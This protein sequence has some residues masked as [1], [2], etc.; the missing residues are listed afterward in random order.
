MSD[1]AR[2]DQKMPLGHRGE[3]SRA[4]LLPAIVLIIV[5]DFVAR[6]HDTEHRPG[7]LRPYGPSVA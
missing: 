4:A 3:L 7:S 6:W 2:L 1:L 5:F